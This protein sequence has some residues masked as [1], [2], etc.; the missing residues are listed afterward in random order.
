MM[1]VIDEMSFVDD[2]RDR[3]DVDDYCVDDFDRMIDWMMIEMIDRC[4]DEIDEIDRVRDC[5]HEMNHDD[6][7]VNNM[8]SVDLMEMNEMD[9]H[10]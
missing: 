1:M 2:Y 5:D 7:R 6:R 9:D 8:I 10:H 4:Y 3:D